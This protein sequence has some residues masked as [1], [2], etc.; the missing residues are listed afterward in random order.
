MSK[1]CDE[2]G[3]EFANIRTVGR[4]QRFCSPRCRN[5]SHTRIYRDRRREERRTLTGDRGQPGNPW[6]GHKICPDCGAHRWTM[7]FAGRLSD[8]EW[9]CLDPSHPQGYLRI[10]VPR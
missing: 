1:A 10:E 4:P 3:Q 9:V 8:W 6:A 7:P 2:C 5:R